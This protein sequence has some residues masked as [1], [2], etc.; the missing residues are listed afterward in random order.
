MCTSVYKSTGPLFSGSPH[1]GL[2]PQP[3]PSLSLSLLSLSLYLCHS[4]SFN[5]SL[6]LA[7]SVRQYKSRHVLAGHQKQ[8][9][10]RIWF[11]EHRGGGRSQPDRGKPGEGPQYDS[12]LHAFIHNIS[13][14]VATLIRYAYKVNNYFYYLS[15]LVFLQFFVK[16][17]LAR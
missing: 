6:S 17:E 3:S 11:L 15:R 13:P 4:H 2:I 12:A 5:L 8:A 10:C 7:P 16:I 1:A 9:G 14:H